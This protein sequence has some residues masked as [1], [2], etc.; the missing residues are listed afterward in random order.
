MEKHRGIVIYTAIA[1][2]TC[3]A[4]SAFVTSAGVSH[5]FNQEY[6]IYYNQT[7]CHSRYFEIGKLFTGSFL[8]IAR[9]AFIPTLTWCLVMVIMRVF[10][11]RR[12]S[13]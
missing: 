1:L 4:F 10:K 9:W 5:N 7:D 8:F 2:L 12:A 11:K 13:L 6:C 3:V